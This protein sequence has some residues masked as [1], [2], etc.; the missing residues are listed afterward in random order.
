MTVKQ[1]GTYYVSVDNACG[2]NADT[3]EVFS[4]CDFG[5]YIPNAFTPNGDSHNDFFGLPKLN[6]N[7]L[8][9]LQIYNRWG[10][11]IFHTSNRDG[12]WDGTYKGQQAP[13]GTYTYVLMVETLDKKRVVQKGLITLVR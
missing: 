13:T 4:E 5:V 1:P 9:S 12:R 3:V 2:S 8:L 11:L 10:Q 6:K 7:K